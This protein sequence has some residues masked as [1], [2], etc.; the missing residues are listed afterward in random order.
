MRG[1]P[2][3]CL[4]RCRLMVWRTFEAS[5]EPDPE[6]VLRSSGKPRMGQCS[7]KPPDFVSG[8]GLR[9]PMCN[10]VNGVRTVRLVPTSH[11]LFG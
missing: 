1:R 7:M 6:I 10:A 11:G 4:N 5:M 2:S 3:S 9:A 8:P